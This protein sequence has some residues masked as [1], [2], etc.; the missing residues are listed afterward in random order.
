MKT[1][2]GKDLVER[3]SVDALTQIKEWS[4]IS[5]RCLNE[6]AFDEK[7]RVNPDVQYYFDLKYDARKFEAL[8]TAIEKILED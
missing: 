1:Q 5:K 8:I 4:E 6:T 7:R 3:L 2:H